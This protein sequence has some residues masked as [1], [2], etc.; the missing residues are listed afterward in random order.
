MEK[1]KLSLRC[2]RIEILLGCI[3]PAVE[4][5]E[6]MNRITAN[7]FSRGCT[8]ALLSILSIGAWAQT[9]RQVDVKR[10]TVVYVAGNDLVVRTEDGDLRNFVV[11]SD[12]KFTVDGKEVGVQDLTPGTKLTQTISVTTEERMVTDVRSVDAKVLEV[13]PPYLT[14]MTGDKEKYVRVPEGTRFTID[15]KE[16]KLSDL[17]AGMHV[18]GTLVTAV[19]T[20]V[21]YRT[22]K[23][24]GQAPK[25]VETP[26]VVGVLLI[27]EE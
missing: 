1:T 6:F 5:S 27:V 17:H 20:T 12:S 8:L 23:V 18:K 21:A 16:L 19:P 22:N 25:P 3:M 2:N 9:T 7:T 13:K 14:V 10:G 26:A 11:P 4:R 15:G 24:T